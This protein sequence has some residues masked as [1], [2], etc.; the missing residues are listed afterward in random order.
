MKKIWNWFT[1]KKTEIVT[2]LYLA[3]KIASKI[4]PKI[5][6]FDPIAD[7]IYMFLISGTLAHRGLR[8]TLKK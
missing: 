5:T 7:D 4:D 3:Y 2:G 1:G 8:K 6:V